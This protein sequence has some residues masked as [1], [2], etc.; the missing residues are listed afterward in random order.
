MGQRLVITVV[1]NETD[2]AKIYYHWSAYS[3]CALEEAKQLIDHIL[4]HKTMDND[5]RLQLV[6][7]LEANGG[8]IDGGYE[9]EEF[10]TFSK[11]YPN[12]SFNECPS[13]NDGL[14]SFT[15][16]G[17]RDMQRW[18]EGDIFIDLDSKMLYN[19]VFSIDTIEELREW[20]DEDI[21]LEDIPEYDINIDEI[22][23]DEIGDV[24]NELEK[25][26]NDGGRFRKENDIYS[27]IY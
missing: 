13:R 17:M 16:A 9:S 3:V 25:I 8:G 18:S 14:I 1:Q 5:L 10:K 23:F 24:I 26:E 6:K 7:Y 2:L 27:L 15:K 22:P 19:T 4:T 21:K 12:E 11:L 20:Y